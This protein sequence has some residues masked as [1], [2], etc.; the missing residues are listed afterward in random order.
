MLQSEKSL[1][2]TRSATIL[3]IAISLAACGTADSVLFKPNEA[4]TQSDAG[5]VQVAI[6]SVEQWDDV[7][8][9]LQPKFDLSPK[10]ALD[11]VVPITA[12]L[13]ERFLNAVG[14][15]LGVGLPRSSE[16]ETDITE[17][18]AE[19]VETTTES[20][21]ESR[22]PGTV[23]QPDTGLP[24][25]VP[26]PDLPSATADLEIDPFIRYSTALSLYQEV[27]LINRYVRNAALRYGYVPYFV[28][29]H[30]SLS[31]YGRQRPYDV[32]SK[33]SFFTPPVASLN[34]EVVDSALASTNA[35]QYDL[36]YVIPLIVTDNLEGTRSS[37][38]A[39]L[40]RQLSLALNLMVKGVG[41]EAGFN[42]LNENLK[43]I[44][45]TDLNSLQSVSRLTDSSVQ[46]RF[47]AARQ[48]TAGYEMVARAY[49]LSTVVLVP[50]KYIEAASDEDRMLSIIAK[51][52]WRHAETGKELPGPSKRAFVAKLDSKLE[53]FLT[54]AAQKEWG[55]RTVAD[56]ALIGLSLTD[57]IHRSDFAAFV[58]TLREHELTLLSS[59][60]PYSLWIEITDLVAESRFQSASV[61][62]PRR[63]VP[64]GLSNVSQTL[65][66]VDDSKGSTTLRLHDVRGLAPDLAEVRLHPKGC[67]ANSPVI[68][69][70]PTGVA[71]AN[72]GRDLIFSFPSLKALELSPTGDEGCVTVSQRSG[73]WGSS[74]AIASKEFQNVRYVVAKGKAESTFQ[75]RTTVTAIK[76]DKGK[77]T[78]KL[79]VEKMKA[80]KLE[81]AFVNADLE[82]VSANPANALTRQQGKITL[83]KAAEIDL[84]FRNLTPQRPVRIEAKATKAGK[85]AGADT[86]LL[87]VN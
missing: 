56:K 64:A 73:Q 31:P 37:R 53:E 63:T 76:A 10:Q 55:K 12:V 68:Q 14:F 28:R 66:L 57:T 48:P 17:V 35:K 72:G 79:Y 58:T 61:N 30:I 22:E 67:G 82:A 85:P 1:L 15:R 42:A 51:S 33:I 39:E 45:G 21:T 44:A 16:L 59:A 71:V 23:P 54:Q 27:Q 70:A 69:L 5:T 11:S 62:L 83:T 3:A 84:T 9:T 36:P 47:G 78:F 4:K 2:A 41:A 86:L 8:P 77:A 18:S 34:A 32:F 50:R 29:M 19:G 81:L 38:S 7:A 49:S 24:A 40:A 87:E 75:L 13:N 74:T 26:L 43:A 25:N 60:S 52:V 46:V 20:K 80:E 65:V 6:V